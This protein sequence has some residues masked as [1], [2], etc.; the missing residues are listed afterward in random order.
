[1]KNLAS[2]NVDINIKPLCVNEAINRLAGTFTQ[3]QQTLGS[4]E[5]HNIGYSKE[6]L[7]EV[8]NALITLAVIKAFGIGK[9][10]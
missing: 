7:E 9:K 6:F 3:I 8:E 2:K 4:V 10:I 1:M 5:I